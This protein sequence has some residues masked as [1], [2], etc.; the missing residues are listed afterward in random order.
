MA[1]ATGPLIVDHGSRNNIRY[2]ATATDWTQR[3]DS[4]T[5]EGIAFMD[6]AHWV[7]SALRSKLVT[8]AGNLRTTYAPASISCFSRG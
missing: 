4:L 7:N 8:H 2:N 1:C 5:G 6:T 3:R